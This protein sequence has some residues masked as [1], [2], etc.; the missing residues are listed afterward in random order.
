MFLG[1]VPPLHAPLSLCPIVCH[2]KVRFSVHPPLCVSPSHPCAFLCT[3]TP[4]DW[5]NGKMGHRETGTLGHR[6]TG[7]MIHRDT[8]TMFLR[9][10]HSRPCLCISFALPPC[11]CVS[12][13]PAK[14]NERLHWN[15]GT[16]GHQY[17]G[18]L[19]Q[20]DTGRMGWVEV[21]T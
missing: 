4:G 20:W 5:D 6:D 7:T 16:S 21:S 3:G 12:F 9:F 2:K 14:L 1:G 17:T 11:L 18:I 15:I 8:G 13:V 10:V 19:G